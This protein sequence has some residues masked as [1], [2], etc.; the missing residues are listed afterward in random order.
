MT[1]TYNKN[2]VIVIVTA[3]DAGQAVR[4][5]TQ[6]GIAA[7]HS[8]LVPVVTSTRWLRILSSRQE[9]D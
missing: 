4:L 7:V 9:H 5:L 6:R 8:D 1:W 3:E 2:E